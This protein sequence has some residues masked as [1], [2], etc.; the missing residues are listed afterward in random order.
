MPQASIASSV[1]GV[2]VIDCS[3]G[4][5]IPR[6]V[7]TPVQTTP[8]V[9]VAWQPYWLSLHMKEKGTVQQHYWLPTTDSTNGQHMQKTTGQASSGSDWRAKNPA[10]GAGSLIPPKIWQIM[11]PKKQSDSGLAID[12]EKLK[13]TASWLAKNT[14]YT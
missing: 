5:G 2:R 12:P 11:L 13:D 6:S 4:V 8:G 9:A 10:V 14:D 3:V 7:T 1:E